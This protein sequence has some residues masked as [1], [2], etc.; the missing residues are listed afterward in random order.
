MPGVCCRANMKVMC[1]LMSCAS[2]CRR[3]L[4]A[5][6]ATL[7]ACILLPDTGVTL[8]LP[9]DYIHNR[10]FEVTEDSVVLA[11]EMSQRCECF[12]RL[13][14][15][16]RQKVNYAILYPAGICH[17]CLFSHAVTCHNHGAVHSQRR[18]G[19]CVRICMQHHS[20]TSPACHDLVLAM[21][22]RCMLFATTCRCAIHAVHVM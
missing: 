4:I 20:D 22:P 1:M 19:V 17:R 13:K 15:L 8:A 3:N 7:P 6:Q 12:C 5:Q 9:L 11:L 16:S 10:D 14:C 18:H 2:A 21:L